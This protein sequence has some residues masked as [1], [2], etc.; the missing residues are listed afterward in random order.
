MSCFD[1]ATHHGL[2]SHVFA[3][4]FAASGVRYVEML[5][6]DK[7][8]FKGEIKR[9]PGGLLGVVRGGALFYTALLPGAQLHLNPW[10]FCARVWA[11]CR[12]RAVS[13]SC[14]PATSTCCG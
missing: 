13:A 14:S 2:R 4:V 11:R 8:V 1:V 5:L 6:D 7:M 12:T 10:A 3:C 9:A